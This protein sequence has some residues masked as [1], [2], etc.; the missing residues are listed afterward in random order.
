[1]VLG[2]SNHHLCVLLFCVTDKTYLGRLELKFL[3]SRGRRIQLS[4]KC[5]V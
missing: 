5:L 4:M 3:R 1:M 2:S